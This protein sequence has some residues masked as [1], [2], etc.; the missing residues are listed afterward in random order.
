LAVEVFTKLTVNSRPS[1]LSEKVAWAE[2]AEPN[3]EAY[4]NVALDPAASVNGSA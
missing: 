4:S 3:V 2:P 1:A